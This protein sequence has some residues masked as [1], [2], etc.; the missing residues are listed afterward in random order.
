[1]TASTNLIFGFIPENWDLARE[2]ISIGDEESSGT[3]EVSMKILE[4]EC[5]HLKMH[6]VP[7]D[8]GIY[9]PNSPFW[10][11][12]KILLE[13]EFSDVKAKISATKLGRAYAIFTEEDDDWTGLEFVVGPVDGGEFRNDDCKYNGCYYFGY[14]YEE[15]GEYFEERVVVFK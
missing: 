8:S 14:V 4:D 12:V 2:R 5:L 6:K 13:H 1:M 9:K 11:K 10:K 3:K 15:N 7:V